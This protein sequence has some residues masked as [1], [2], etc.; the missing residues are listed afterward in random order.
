MFRVHMQRVRYAAAAVLLAATPLQ[1]GPFLLWQAAS[2]TG[3]RAAGAP[4]TYRLEPLVLEADAGLAG[5]IV[6]LPLGGGSRAS[7]RIA[8]HRLDPDR[9]AMTLSGRAGGS[10]SINMTL[11]VVG[12]QISGA[13]QLPGRRL[14]EI[15]GAVDAFEVREAEP[16]DRPACGGGLTL[17]AGLSRPAPAFAPAAMPLNASGTVTVDVMIVYTPQA[18]IAAGGTNAIEAAIVQSVAQANAV[19]SNSAIAAT[20]RLV[21]TAEVTYND[22]GNMVDD[23]ERITGQADGFMDEVHCLRDRYGADLISLV[24]NNGQ[25]GGLAWILCD[26]S[27]FDPGRGFSIVARNLLTQYVVAHEFGHNFGCD[28][29]PDNPSG[30]RAHSYSYG[31]RFIND[32]VF[33]NKTVMAYDPGFTV[34]HF[35]NPSANWFGVPTGTASRNNARTI[36]ETLATIAAYRQPQID[37]NHP[38]FI[39]DCFADAPGYLLAN[40]GM[41]LYAAVRSNLLYVAGWSSGI[42]P[43]DTGRSDHFIF[44]SDQRLS[45]ASAPAPWA[46]SGLIAVPASAPF[47]AAESMNDYVAWFNVPGASAANKHPQNSGQMEGY[48]DLVETFGY[49]PATVYLAAVAYQTTNGGALVAQAPA[50]SGPNLDPNEL[51]AVPLA[52]IID[53]NLDGVFDRLDPAF[54]FLAHEALPTTN[55]LMRITWASVPGQAYRVERAFT[56]QPASW[57]LVQVVTGA[58]AQAFMSW[59]DAATPGTSAVYRIRLGN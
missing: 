21:H 59:T 26:P 48:F 39:M 1:A 30:C 32:G 33:T 5:A 58:P 17:P 7:M 4:E 54:D 31:H 51:L 49:V 36:R 45:S 41:T 37:P 53:R 23:L 46:K 6:E 43:G 47:L 2:P 34:P 10:E 57:P 35:S 44:V 25:F 19:F 22:S 12:D 28:H 29:D 14:L 16:F 55:G 40:P 50:G 8:E 11:A 18:R 42:Y 24:V 56:P 13:L 15:S 3:P 9:A 38:N 27:S 52:T 20:Y